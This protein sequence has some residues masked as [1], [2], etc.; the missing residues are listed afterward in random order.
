[1]NEN[2]KV[3]DFLKTLQALRVVNGTCRGA[4]KGNCHGVK[5][6]EENLC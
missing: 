4:V 1:M 5:D 6:Y 2:P 3:R